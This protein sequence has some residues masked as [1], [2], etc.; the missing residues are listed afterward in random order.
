RTKKKDIYVISTSKRPVPLEHYLYVEKE[1]YK[2]VGA[3]KRFLSDGWKA[4]FDAL[5]STKR[6]ENQKDKRPTGRGDGGR[7]GRGGRGGGG[8]GGAVVSRGGVGG[9]GSGASS[10]S[11]SRDLS[12][13]NLY[14]QLLNMLKKK[15]LLPV[16]IFSFSKK[17]CEEYSNA[18][19]NLDFTSGGTEK[20]EIHVFIEKSLAKL[21]GTDKQLPQVLRIR[22]LLSRGIAVHHGGLLPIIKEM[23]EILFTRGLVKVL[24]A[25]ETFA[26]GV[27]AP[28][29]CVVFSMIRKHDGRNFRELLPGEYTQMSG[30]A[31]RRGLD[32]TG[33]VIIACNDSVPELPTLNQMILGTPTKLESQ[34]RLTYTMI[35]N[36]LRVE[37]LKVEE[38][39]KRSFSENAAQKMLPEQQKLFDD[40]QKA[41]S[42]LKKLSCT[43][44]AED[45]D[46]YYEMSSRVVLL[47]HQLRERI[48]RNP[49]GTKA[50]GVGRV[51]VVNSGFVRNAMGVIVKAGSVPPMAVAGNT[52]V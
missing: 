41:L 24:F 50:A 10:N 28:A 45:L 31:G 52:A 36:L 18:L 7:G 3:E 23:V 44:C 8:R 43:I 14:I 25:T 34:F 11:F 15:N 27:N 4:G 5:A 29:K 9:G 20:S 46:G 39:I 35:L 32:D 38:M 13:R 49:V 37:A 22:D 26:M 48:I 2:I 1:I 33:V 16:I 47:G 6:A 30:R 17:K 12:D 19:T 21:K 51:V 42:S 40:S